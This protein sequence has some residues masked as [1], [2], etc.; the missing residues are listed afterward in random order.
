MD[1]ILNEP[2]YQWDTGRVVE[3]APDDGETIDE[4][5]FSNV[6]C[7]EA[8]VV[9]PKGNHADIPN[10]LLQRNASINVHVVV[11]MNDGKRTVFAKKLSAV[12]GRP[13]PSDY[14]YQ[15]TDILRWEYMQSQIDLMRNDIPTKTSSL[16]NDSGFIDEERMNETA[17]EI[18]QQAQN[19]TDVEIAKFDFVKI[20]PE[21]PET[22]VS[23]RTYFVPKSSE[24]A[25]ND[26]YD[27][28]M[29][30]DGKW[31]FIGTKE[32]EIDLTD[33][34]KN[35]DYASASQAG[36]IFVG[37][38]RG[39][40]AIDKQYNIYLNRASA[41]EIK[42]LAN[43]YNPIVPGNLKLAVETVGGELEGL[44][45]DD[46]S[47]YTASINEVLGKIP[48]D[49]HIDELIMAQLEVIENGTY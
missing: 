48:S 4:V 25:Q 49:E 10:I 24:T 17:S 43:L 6:Y 32:I 19:Y 1:I 21:L 34:V 15:E 3:L 37:K 29:W 8:L 22:G 31:E 23:N 14:F 28:Y 26:L 45:T 39:G 2:L 9:K 12:I 40:I 20:V 38:W 13:K 5:H 7:K 44:S 42:K 35:T 41:E 30:I 11:I 33:Y 16:E 47:S 36:V 27:E 46:K 18:L